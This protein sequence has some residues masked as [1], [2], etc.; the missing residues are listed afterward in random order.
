M[1]GDFAC[2][3]PPN[4]KTLTAEEAWVP[5]AL[6]SSYQIRW[7]IFQTE[8]RGSPK[9]YRVWALFGNAPSINAIFENVC[10]KM[11]WVEKPD[12]Q[13]HRRATVAIHPQGSLRLDRCLGWLWVSRVGSGPKA[14]GKNMGHGQNQLAAIHT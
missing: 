1:K 2:L 14:N 8:G 6:N 13:Q 11:P 7:Y 5:R 10:D 4:L 3:S 9:N 12:P